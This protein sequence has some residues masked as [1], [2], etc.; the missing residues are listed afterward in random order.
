MKLDVILATYNRAQLLP[1]AIEAFLAARVPAGVEARILIV[2]NAST[3]ATEA[4]VKPYAE[5]YPGRVRYLHEGRRGRAH[6]L[7]A[8]IAA[9]GGELVGFLDDDETVTADWIEVVYRE[10]GEP[11]LDFIGGP[12]VPNWL[13]PRP[14]WMPAFCHGAIGV[15]DHGK[16]RFH[17]GI[18]EVGL[19]PSGGNVVIRRGALEL[20]GP[21]VDTYEHAEDYDMALR[22]IAA[23]VRGDYVPDLIIHHDIPPRRLTRTFLRHWHYSDGRTRGR[24]YAEGRGRE[25]GTPL[26]GVPRWFYR[27]GARD[28]VTALFDGLRGPTQR[29]VEAQMR[30]IHFAGFVVG[31]WRPPTPPHRRRDRSGD[32]ARA[33]GGATGAPHP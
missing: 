32:Q 10:M 5:A 21:Y 23:G 17:Y 13:A 4:A 3:D 27:R 25:V 2:D 1:R 19:H 33:P 15:I 11:G 14:D 20:V 22:L 16:C 26:L 9:T 31:R 8:G 30:A 28:T 24:I 18:D 29:G 6:A 12:Y 7:N